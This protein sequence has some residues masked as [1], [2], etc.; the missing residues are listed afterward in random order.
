MLTA[1]EALLRLK[2]GNRKYCAQAGIGDVSAAVRERTLHEGQTP[3]AVILACADSRV[4]PESIFTAGIGELFV[5][6]AAGNVTDGAILGSIEYAVAHL[7]C[8]LVVVMGHEKCGAVNAAMQDDYE[9]P[10]G[11]ITRAI[12]AAFTGEADE[13]TVCRRNVERQAALISRELHLNDAGVK[14]IGAIYRL[15]DGTVEFI[16]NL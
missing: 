5:I 3:Y 16:E 15:S 9:G 10:I 13:M 7:G 14:T 1:D 12:R 4:I 6:R 8:K 11:T 2:D